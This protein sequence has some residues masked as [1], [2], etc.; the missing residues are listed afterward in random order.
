MSTQEFTF[1]PVFSD[2]VY[3]N[4]FGAE[5]FQDISGSQREF[6][7]CCQTGQSAFC[8]HHVFP[9]ETHRFQFLMDLDV[10]AIDERIYSVFRGLLQVGFRNLQIILLDV[11]ARCRQRTETEKRTK[12]KGP[13]YIG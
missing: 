10:N 12:T 1:I 8:W 4:A 3:R 9:S 5:S 2:V 11:S 7:E 13:T 6:L